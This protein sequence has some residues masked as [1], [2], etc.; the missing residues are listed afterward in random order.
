M[1]KTVADLVNAANGEWAH[2]GNSTWNVLTGAKHIV[3]SDDDPTFASYVVDNYCS[4]VS[5]QP[6]ATEIANDDYAWSAVGMTAFFKAAGFAKT[7]F[8]FS[9]R[10]SVWIRAF[11]KARKNGTPALYHAYR[12]TDPQA[13]P[14]V[15]D[16]VGYARDGISFA[17]AQACYDKTVHYP[18]HTDLVVAK[19][20]G[21][22]DVIGANVRDS[23]TKKTLRI[24]A[25]GQFTDQSHKWFVARQ[26]AA[27]ADPSAHPEPRAAEGG[28]DG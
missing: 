8:P 10:H 28:R 11:V 19:R 26:S 22:I 24:G 25:N 2:W 23:V 21:E 5:D 27:A 18:A 15:G 3:H 14:E 9:N 17:D 16:L 13:T 7:E 12:L 20:P 1:A 6:T 4:I